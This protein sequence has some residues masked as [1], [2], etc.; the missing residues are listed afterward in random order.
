MLL[1]VPARA[2]GSIPS[3]G[4]REHAFFVWPPPAPPA[5]SGIRFTSL[6]HIVASDPLGSVR[7]ARDL[8]GSPAHL[9]AY[10]DRVLLVHESE[11]PEVAPGSTGDAPPARRRVEAVTAARAAIGGA[12]YEYRPVGRDPEALPSLP[13]SGVLLDVALTKSGAFALLSERGRLTLLALSQTEWKPAPLPDARAPFRPALLVL[14]D[15]LILAER[16]ARRPGAEGAPPARVWSADP[17][18]LLAGADTSDP[19]AWADAGL[20][21]PSEGEDLLVAADSLI[22]CRRAPSGEVSLRL[23]RPGG[24]SHALASI[25]GVGAD[26]AVVPSGERVSVVWFQTDKAGPRQH[27]ATVSAITGRTLY[28]GLASPGAVVSAR[29]LLTL[30]LLLGAVLLTALVFILRPEPADS[31]VIV[32]PPGTALAGPGRRFVAAC[33]DLGLPALIVSRAFAISPGEIL[34]A[35]LLS[36]D[37]GLGGA[38]ALLALLFLT[39]LHTSVSE[40]LAGSTLGKSLVRCRT[41]SAKGGRPAFWQAVVRNALKLLCPPLALFLLVDPRARH[42]ADVLARTVV[43]VTIKPDAPSPPD[44]GDT[45]SGPS[46]E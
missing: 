37:A 34:E 1:A 42:P 41:V 44:S 16:E 12:F 19:G 11:P 9:S 7:H 29:S 26:F 6:H 5:S 31:Q 4:S 32:L 22:A 25:P 39:I 3:A 21:A 46:G 15:R 38:G 10:A 45:G 13:E 30:A 18:T 23:L 2:A 14:A 35:S 33:V 24:A 17:E 40:W 43:V 36:P 20:G 8:P 28:T 27:V